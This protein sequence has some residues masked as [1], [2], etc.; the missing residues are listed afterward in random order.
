M[1]MSNSAFANNQGIA[2][3]KFNLGQVTIANGVARLQLDPGASLTLP[4]SNVFLAPGVSTAP[5]GL[6]GL[7]FLTGAGQA[8]A[9]LINSAPVLST[10]YLIP[11]N[12]SVVFSTNSNGSYIN[13]QINVTGSGVDNANLQGKYTGNFSGSYVGS[14]A[15]N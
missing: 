10:Y 1:L 6:G 8:L 7:G 2:S 13:G 12:G 14:T 9:Q 11:R 5:G 4:P 3:A 15:C